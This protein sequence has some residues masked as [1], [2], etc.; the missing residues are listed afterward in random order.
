MQPPPYPVEPD[1]IIASHVPILLAFPVI[2]HFDYGLPTLS[3]QIAISLCSIYLSRFLSHTSC[4]VPHLSSY[5]IFF[6]RLSY[7]T[8]K[9]VGAF[10]FVVKTENKITLNGYVFFLSSFFPLSQEAERAFPPLTPSV[11]FSLHCSPE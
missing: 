4:K 6:P 10:F 7:F 5:I 9:T 2:I 11:P 1:K 8:H 3:L